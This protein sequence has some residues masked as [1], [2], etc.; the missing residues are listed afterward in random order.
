MFTRIMTAVVMAPL[1]IALLWLMP[2][3]AGVALV[4]LAAL[5]AFD[6]FLRMDGLGGAGGFLAR[7]LPH[8]CMLGLLATTIVA[9]GFLI[10]TLFLSLAVL[11]VRR[12]A[13]AGD[14]K[15]WIA[16]VALPVVGLVWIGMPMALLAQTL[17]VFPEVGRNLTLGLFAI[18]WLGDTLA[19]FGGRTLGRHKL[20]PAVSPKKTVEGGIFGLLGSVLGGYI[21]FR[22]LPL[23]G[24]GLYQFLGLALLCGVAEQVGDF[25][26]SMVKRA[27]NL[28][29][30]GSILPGHG[31]MMDRIDGLLFA[32]PVLYFGWMLLG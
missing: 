9:P 12:M 17:Y 28:K 21:S 2:G 32:I 25:S 10:G 13:A 20:Y 23:P 18:V 11:L 27:A 16:R 5:V 8:L 7:T 4:G 1:V 3:T 31:G 15:D 14:F 30:S 22:W 6:E 24:L 26:E 29:D 19:Y